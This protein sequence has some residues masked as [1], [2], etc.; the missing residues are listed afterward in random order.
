MRMKTKFQACLLTISMM[1]LFGTVLYG[2]DSSFT[3]HVTDITGAAIPK[4][5]IIVHNEGTNV[6]ITTQT[7][8]NGDYTVPYL[9]P[10]SYTVSATAPGFSP[11]VKTAIPLESAKT[12]TED[13]TLKVGAT[14]EKVVVESA[15]LLLDPGKADLSDTISVEEVDDLPINGRDP[16]MLMELAPATNAWAATWSQ[17]PFD[18][19]EAFMMVSGGGSDYNWSGDNAI[20]LDGTPNTQ[21]GTGPGYDS[22]YKLPVDVVAEVKVSSTPYDA[23]YGKGTGAALDETLKS[24]TNQFHGDVYFYAKRPWLDANTWVNDY[25]RATLPPSQASEFSLSPYTQNDYGTEINGPVVIPKL[26]NGKDKTFYLLAFENWHDNAPGT[27]VSSVPDPTWFTGDFSNLTN[28]QNG[29]PTHVTLYDPTTIHQNAAGVWVRA[30]YGCPPTSDITTCAGTNIIP[31]ADINPIAVNYLSLYAKPNTTAPAGYN[32]YDNNLA[33]YAASPDIYRNWLVKLDHNFSSRDRGSARW[34]FWER[35]QSGLQG[36]VLPSSPACCWATFERSQNFAVDWVHTFS[37]TLVLDSRATANTFHFGFPGVEPGFDYASLGWSSSVAALLQPHSYSSLPWVMPGNFTCIP[38]GGG[39]GGSTANFLGINPSLTWVKGKQTFKAGIDLRFNQTAATYADEVPSLST[40]GNWTQQNYSQSDP[41]SGSP[42]ADFLL[43]DLSSGSINRQVLPFFS[44]HYYAYYLQDDWKF[45]SKLTLNL[46]IRWDIDPSYVERHN[47]MNY[48]WDTTDTNPI[49]S[50]LSNGLA[51]LG[52]PT[53]VGVNGNPRTLYATN[54]GDFQPR[55]GAAYALNDKTVLRGGFGEWYNSSQAG[56]QAMGFNNTTNLTYSGDGGKTPYNTLSNPF[57]VIYQPIGSS[58]GLETQVGNSASY[59]NPHYH[60]P[61]S[62]NYTFGIERA[63]T[64]HDTLSVNYVGNRGEGLNTWEDINR[65]SLSSIESCNLDMGAT[66]AAFNNCINAAPVNPFY[67][68]PAFAGSGLGASPTLQGNAQQLTRPEPEWGDIYENNM[69]AGHSW[70]NSLQVTAEH[71]WKN[72][73][74]THATYAWQK[75]MEAGGWKDVN[76][77]IPIRSIYSWNVPHRVTIASTYQLPVGRGHMVLDNA[78]RLVD[79]AVGGWELGGV[80]IFQSGQ[81]W[82]IP[83]GLNQ[84]GPAYVKPHTDPSTGLIVGVKACILQWQQDPTT[85]NWSDNLL[86][87]NYATDCS[88]PDFQVI[89]P[90]G[91]TTNTVYSGV[92]EFDNSSFDMNMMK[93]FSIYE[94][95]KLELRFEMLNAFNHPIWGSS[96]QGAF[97]DSGYGDA[98]FGSFNKLNGQ[99]NNPRTCQIA[100][101]LKW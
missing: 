72:S 48:A 94:R 25:Y 31:G 10:G 53:W 13:F 12:A 65:E 91:Q 27:D 14:T 60:I 2:Q 20:T 43:G 101:T 69:N 44:T 86:P 85:G 40:G 29:V 46:G 38:C 42:I 41:L 84:I 4:A 83:G 35:G 51:V 89:P 98:T 96:F 36:G 81:P 73:L 99:L 78:N 1:V 59:T 90:W 22:S 21:A 50:Q 70:Y 58:Q 7:N 80:Y 79:G 24:G 47:Y 95:M 37:S 5:A 17:R 97:Y 33:V 19:P 62:W 30:P 55:I 77:R 28:M 64:Q 56:N 57:P 26:Y 87:L 3:G 32:F 54:W 39:P 34:G 15:P 66:S 23:S 76:Y 52:G 6:D 100:A 49:S 11:E 71:K 9:V 75:E 74:T 45:T 63:F 68:I 88:Q 16:D 93:N 61:H 92:K 82:P 67:N 18:Q 8:G